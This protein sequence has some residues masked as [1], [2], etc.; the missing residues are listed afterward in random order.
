M[1]V[2]FIWRTAGEIMHEELPG[3][4]GQWPLAKHSRV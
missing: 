1:Q 3:I 4:G 2:R